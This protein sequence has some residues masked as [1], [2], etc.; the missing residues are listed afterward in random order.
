MESEYALKNLTMMT[1]TGFKYP[2]IPFNI[3][4]NVTMAASINKFRTARNLLLAEWID[5]YRAAFPLQKNFIIDDRPKLLKKLTEIVKTKEN[6]F[7]ELEVAKSEMATAELAAKIQAKYKDRIDANNDTSWHKAFFEEYG[8]INSLVQST[9]EST[10]VGQWLALIDKDIE[11]YKTKSQF[12]VELAKEQ[13]QTAVDKAE[14]YDR[15]VAMHNNTIKELMDSLQEV[16]FCLIFLLI[17]Y[18]LRNFGKIF[19]WLVGL[20]ELY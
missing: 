14:M 18:H 4:T 13:T 5:Q 15:G 10:P 11:H 2:I 17:F 16:N 20:K 6:Y 7:R 1:I 8:E 9:F 19:F 12:N 3:E